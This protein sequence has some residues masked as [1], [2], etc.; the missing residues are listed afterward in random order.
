[1]SNGVTAKWIGIIATIIIVL[2]FGTVSVIIAD[3][4]RRQFNTESDVRRMDKNQVL[5][6]YQLKEINGK[7]DR[8]LGRCTM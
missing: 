4:T 1:M 8:L 5:I 2:G 7:L 3:Q 6:I